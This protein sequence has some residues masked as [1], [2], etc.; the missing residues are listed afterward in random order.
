MSNR[1]L[2]QFPLPNCDKKKKTIFQGLAEWLK[3]YST[4]LASMR[5]SN[6]ST[7]KGKKKS[8]QKLPY[9]PWVKITSG[10]ELLVWSLWK[11]FRGSTSKKM[12]LD[13]HL[14]LKNKCE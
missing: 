4:C 12:K 11:S 5:P 10:Q 8:L 6:P 1:I 14:T 9:N 3:W 7:T 13:P 2:M